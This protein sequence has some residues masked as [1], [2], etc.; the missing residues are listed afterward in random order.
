M[1]PCHF[2]FPPSYQFR[3]GAEI[4]GLVSLFEAENPGARLGSL[5]PTMFRF[6]VNATEQLLAGGGVPRALADKAL[7]EASSGS[8][9]ISAVMETSQLFGS[10]LQ[11]RKLTLA[12]DVPQLHQLGE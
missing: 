9:S 8:K 5:G 12:D 1:P 11:K 2:F 3:D 6:E 7:R 4:D 10:Y